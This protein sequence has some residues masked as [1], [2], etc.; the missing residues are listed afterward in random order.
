MTIQTQTQAVPAARARRA[1]GWRLDGLALLLSAPALL[2]LLLL[3]VYPFVYGVVL[4]LTPKGG[5]SALANYAAFFDDG[6]QVQSIWNTAR[7]AIPVA[8]VNVLL[9][10]PLALKM[11]R[12]MRFERAITILLV[13]PITF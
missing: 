8:A 12:K 1:P 11:R 2:L 5:G 7:L 13:V 4:S 9:S 6:R 3:F 10:V